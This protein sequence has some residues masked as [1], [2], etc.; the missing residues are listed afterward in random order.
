M[1]SQVAV[2]PIAEFACNG[3]VATTDMA[4]ACIKLTGAKAFAANCGS[5]AL[6]RPCTADELVA[7]QAAV[8]GAARLVLAALPREQAEMATIRA[9]VRQR[10]Q[11]KALAWSAE[12]GVVIVL[13]AVLV[14]FRHQIRAAFGHAAVGVAARAVHA[15]RQVK[16]SAQSLQQRIVDRADELDRP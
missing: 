5:L 2:N 15:N 13:L 12:I 11:M 8:D 9:E 1:D 10:E 4:T 14:M 3:Q 16:R 6:Q 7:K